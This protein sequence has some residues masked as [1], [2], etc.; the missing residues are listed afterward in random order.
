MELTKFKAYLED[1]GLMPKTVTAY[2]SCVSLAYRQ[3]N[4]VDTVRRAKSPGRRSQLYAALRQY[5]AYLGGSE[6]AELLMKLTALPRPRVRR[7]PPNRPLDPGEWDRL[8]RSVSEENE[9]LSHVLGLLVVTG[10]RSSDV[11][12]IEHDYVR[13][14]LETGVL[15]LQQKGGSYR[16]FPVQGEIRNMLQQLEDGW[17]YTRLGELLTE[18]S[19]SRADYVAL[20]RGLGRAAARAGLEK[21]R[22]YPHLLRATAAVQLYRRTRDIHAVQQWLGHQDIRTTQ[23]YLRYV[24][25]DDLGESFK[26]LMES[27]RES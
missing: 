8:L 10:L 22:R 1:R 5:A 7:K 4:A 21:E 27:R 13:E 15:Y 24:D 23:E 19:S 14:G 17:T 18:G 11:L 26:T 25:P 3:G 16:P 2:V 12:N 20:Y 9:P 6:G